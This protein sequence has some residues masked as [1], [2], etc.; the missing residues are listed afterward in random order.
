MQYKRDD[1]FLR[2]ADILEVQLF[3]AGGV[4]RLNLNVSEKNVSA[5]NAWPGPLARV[6]PSIET[7]PCGRVSEP[8]MSCLMSLQPVYTG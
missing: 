2:A 4:I 6:F 5:T 1:V 8:E 7:L 3:E